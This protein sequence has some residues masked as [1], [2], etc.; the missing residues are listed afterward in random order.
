[1]WATSA[2]AAGVV[3]AGM[4]ASAVHHDMGQLYKIA[5]QHSLNYPPSFL[6]R[7]LKRLV[8]SLVYLPVQKDS[9]KLLGWC[10]I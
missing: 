6:S 4:V 5:G 1:M 7:F 3:G 2:A 9:G 10:L 8:R